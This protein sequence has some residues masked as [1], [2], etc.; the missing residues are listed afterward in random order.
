[1]KKPQ[2]ITAV[3]ALLLVIG[4]Y[5]ATQQQLFGPPKIKV[6]RSEAAPQ[7]GIP[8]DSLLLHAKEGLNQEQLTRLELLEHSISRGDVKSQKMEIYH[9]LAH[10]WKDTARKFE[11][12][13]WYTAE[14]ARLENSEKSLTFA[15]HLFLNNISNEERPELKQWVALQAKDLFER[16]LKLNPNNDSSKVGLGA[17]YLYGGIDMPMKGIGMIREV[18]DKDSTNVYAQMT[19]GQASLTSGQMDKAIDRFQRV[20][21]LQPSNIEAVLLLAEINE[22]TG[23]KTEAIEWYKRSLPLLKNTAIKQEVEARIAELKK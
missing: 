7:A 6:P 14:A 9:Q 19:L 23:N 20:V 22:Q 13:A 3:I 2:W 21:R 16:S 10:F 18:A 12:Y 8:V 1:M 11:P 15:A 5:A 4:L 17:V